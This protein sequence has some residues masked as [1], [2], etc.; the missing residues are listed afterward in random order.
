MKK[1]AITNAHQLHI[2]TIDHKT[3]L[4]IL[5]NEQELVCRKERLSVI[6][7]FLA[8]GEGRIFKGRLQLEHSGKELQIIVKNQIIGSIAPQLLAK[9]LENNESQ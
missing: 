1:F 2:E 7:A 3:R 5:E 4:I 6:Q 9:A 8:K